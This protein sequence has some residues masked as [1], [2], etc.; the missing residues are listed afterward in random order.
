MSP[1][2]KLVLKI[3]FKHL[4]ALCRQHR[5]RG[6]NSFYDALLPFLEPW[7]IDALYNAFYTILFEEIV[8][9]ENEVLPDLPF[10]KVD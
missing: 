8:L 4:V 5:D 9:S 7:Q 3:A 1:I 2:I 6:D 10:E